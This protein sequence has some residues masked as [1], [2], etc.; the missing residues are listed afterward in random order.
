MIRKRVISSLPVKWMTIQAYPFGKAV[1]F[2]CVL[3]VQHSQQLRQNSLATHLNRTM[4]KE[5][6]LI[7]AGPHLLSILILEIWRFHCMLKKFCRRQNPSSNYYFSDVKTNKHINKLLYAHA[8]MYM[9]FHICLHAS[10][11]R[12]FTS[13]TSCNSCSQHG[14]TFCEMSIAV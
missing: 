5:V 12:N 8:Y 14:V 10:L 7:Y 2:T 3:I 9:Q 11:S 1:M 13:N 6:W 4:W